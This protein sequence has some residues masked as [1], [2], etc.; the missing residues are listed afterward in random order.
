[1]DVPGSTTT[2][3]TADAG[4]LMGILLGVGLAALALGVLMIIAMWRVFTKAGQPGWAAI[5]PIYNTYVLFKIV[6]RPG[7]WVVLMFIPIV[8]VVIAIIA[9][10]DLARSFGKSGVFGF[11][12]LVVFGFVGLFILGFGS[13]RYLGPNG[14]PQQP[15]YYPQPGYGY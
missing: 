15:T 12:G 3:T 7:W 8:N 6:G 14:N 5:V 2:L 10:L 13:A 11:F 4:A 1:M 9:M